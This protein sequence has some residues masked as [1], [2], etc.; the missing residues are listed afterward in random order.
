MKRS[1][2]VPLIILMAG[3]LWG[4]QAAE[5][6]LSPAQTAFKRD[7]SHIIQKLSGVLV[8][9]VCRADARACE[10][11]VEE[12]YPEAGEETHNFPFRIGIL[13]KDGILIYTVPPLKEFA[14]DYSQY[15]VVKQAMKERR[16]LAV[17]L[18]GSD[19][20]P[21]FMVLSPLFRKDEVA[22]LL[23]LRLS[24][25]LAQKKWGLTEKDFL[26][27]KWN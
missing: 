27:L 5:K 24:A 26:D 20:N 21:F 10:A 2:I 13:N 8:E 22:G 19:G 14:D 17:R 6:P 15:Q 23:A 7:I 12:I 25:G 16:L 11:A 4:C 1:Y 18:Y 9:P 3:L